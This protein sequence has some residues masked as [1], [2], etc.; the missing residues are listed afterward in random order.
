[1][2]SVLDKIYSKANELYPVNLRYTDMGY[3]DLNMSKREAFVEGM[4]YA[5]KHT[6]LITDNIEVLGVNKM[7]SESE[8]NYTVNKDLVIGA[9]KSN[10][11]NDI[12]EHLK[13]YI[14]VEE[15]TTNY[16]NLNLKATIRIIK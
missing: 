1:M 5:S 14:K 16:G 9:M 12:F 6:E 7:I 11:M 2:E 3:E 8:L 15:E 4:L 10:M 13:P